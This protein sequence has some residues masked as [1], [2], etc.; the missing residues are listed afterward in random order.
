MG[1][2]DSV[3]VKE[4]PAYVAIESEVTGPVETI[5]EKAYRQDARYVAE[6]HGEQG[7][8]VV[9]LYPEWENKPPTSPSRI[10]VQLVLSTEIN[11]DKLPDG[12]GEGLKVTAMPAATV[13]GCAYR[14][15][16]TFEN[17]KK[18]LARIEE[19]IKQKDLKP[20]GPPRHLYFSNT[21]WTPAFMRVSEVEVPI[22]GGAADTTSHP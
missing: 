8:P 4:Q 16:Y 22:A 2:L 13:V 20:V 11:P 5:W 19:Y 1:E 18:A 15:A 7:W 6:V 3:M 10:L 17:F 14:G 21:A 9:V 12:R